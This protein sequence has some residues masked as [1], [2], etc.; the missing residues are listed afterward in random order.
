MAIQIPFTGNLVADPE[1]RF[2]PNGSAAANF[3]VASNERTLDRDTNEWKDGVTTYLT[4]N[5]WRGL[6][7]NVSETLKKGDQVVVIGRLKQREFETRDR[8]KRTVYEVEADAVGVS[9]A[10]ATATITKSSRQ[11][12]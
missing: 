10:Y 11:G 2:T 7:E 12:D 5:V 3:R 6:A 1:L 9:L 8:E 4:V